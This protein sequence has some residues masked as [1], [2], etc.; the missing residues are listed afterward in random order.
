MSVSSAPPFEI[1]ES[2][3]DPG[4]G[5]VEVRASSMAGPVEVPTGENPIPF[6]EMQME[7]GSFQPPGT[8]SNITLL[9]SEI[10][11]EIQGNPQK[12]SAFPSKTEYVFGEP[13]E[14]QAYF[15]LDS[16]LQWDKALHSQWPDPFIKALP[17]SEWNDYMSQWNDPDSEIE[18]QPYPETTFLPPELWVYEGGGSGGT[19]PCD[20]GLVMGWGEDNPDTGDYASAW[21]YDY[22]DDP[23]LRNST[24]TITV[25]APQFGV[26]G[27]QINA[28]SFAITDTMG[29]RRSWW[30]NVGNPPAAIQ[31][32][33]PTTITI[34]T[35]V[36][37]SSAASP[38]ATGYMNT[39]GFDL[40]QAQC[41]DV[42]ENGS[43]V[44]NSVPVPPPG[45]SNFVGLWNY[46]HNLMVT[47]NV[48]GEE[49]V[50]SKWYVKYSQPPVLIDPNKEPPAISGWD[51]VSDY[52]QGPVMADDFPCYD[53][54]PITD[55]HWWGSFKG[56]DQPEPPRLPDAFHIGIWTDFP[57]PDP[58][59]PSTYSHPETLIWEN[60]C[61]NYVWNFVGYDVDPYQRPEY[62]NET[63]F[64]FTQLLSEDEWF[65][66]E[67]LEDPDQPNIYW[68]SIAPIWAD[69]MQP[70][71]PWGW[72]TRE[73][74]FQDDAVRIRD[75]SIWPVR[76]GSQWTG[77]EPVEVEGQS[78]DLAFEL[79]TN[80][81]GEPDPPSADFTGDDWVDF[82]DFAIFADQWLT[83]GP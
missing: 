7:A 54:R 47:R 30:W 29:R 6:F 10:D 38:T 24:I 51:E 82:E 2:F 27:V 17:E 46:W 28:V 45:T 78:W 48:G 9:S 3:I 74:T 37:G 4:S 63:C 5:T 19:D 16:M 42:D 66:Q 11:A 57:D 41:F 68:L 15:L 32:N 58:D 40:S 73:H 83:T 61:D 52:Q 67:P 44:F 23:D 50:V 65:Q 21:R 39:A 12:I 76:L 49:G 25:T 20:G 80:A 1:L 56:W 53:D 81:P 8:K 13:S 31:W 59:D 55:I 35:A 77:G 79:T 62:E 33:T 70:E 71:Y 22:G 43:W 60:Y 26:S 75:A 36:T 34:N 18:G 69:G 14:C 72:K 64:Q